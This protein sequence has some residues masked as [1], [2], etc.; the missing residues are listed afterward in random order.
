MTLQLKKQ[1]KTEAKDQPRRATCQFVSGPVE[2][3]AP[4]EG[5]VG[6]VVAHDLLL[7]GGR[8]VS[9]WRHLNHAL[10][11]GEDVYVY[12][13][14]LHIDKKGS[15]L[16]FDIDKKHFKMTKT[17]TGFQPSHCVCSYQP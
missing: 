9:E 6:L 4:L 5:A 8:V 7:Y 12:A 14:Y 11:D 17:S 15:A 16:I 10:R 13:F 1:N 3:R 2:F